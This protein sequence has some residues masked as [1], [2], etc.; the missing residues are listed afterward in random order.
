MRRNIAGVLT[1]ALMC[2]CGVARPSIVY[3]VNIT[4]GIETISGTITTDGTTGTLSRR[5]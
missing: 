1:V 4:D 3:D 5:I 2:V